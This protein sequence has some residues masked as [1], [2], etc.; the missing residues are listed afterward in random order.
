MPPLDT[1]VTSPQNTVL[2]YTPRFSKFLSD[3]D[4]PSQE[5]IHNHQPIPAEA[6]VMRLHD[7]RRRFAKGTHVDKESKCAPTDRQLVLDIYNRALSAL[8]RLPKDHTQIEAEC[9]RKVR[10]VLGIV[11]ADPD[12]PVF[13]TNGQ[14]LK[15]LEPQYANPRL[16]HSEDPYGRLAHWRLSAWREDGWPARYPAQ[17]LRAEKKRG[18]QLVDENGTQKMKDR[19]MLNKVIED[20][21]M[22]EDK[23]VGYGGRSS[24][25]EDALDW[26]RARSRRKE[27]SKASVKARAETEYTGPSTRR[28]QRR[29]HDGDEFRDIEDP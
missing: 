26:A 11:S 14:L 9:N 15:P 22:W 5:F 3:E 17:A 13:T 10:V 29:D 7:A 4:M 1:P 24:E 19:A 16:S 18:Q 6:T 12:D 2:V 20:Q 25:K 27:K 21:E 28:K 8:P 23:G